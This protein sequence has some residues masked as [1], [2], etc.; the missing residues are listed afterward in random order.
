MMY[1]LWATILKDTRILIRDP[2]G[3]TFMFAMPVL[4]VLIMTSI[5]NNTFELVNKNQT[6]LLLCNRDTGAISAELVQAISKID[7]FKIVPLA[8]DQTEKQITDRMQSKDALLAM[9]I[10]S[11]FSSKI[12]AKAKKLTGKALNSFGLSGD[13]V[14]PGA[15]NLDPLILY[16]HPVIQPSFR[17][18]VQGALGSA[19][20]LVESRQVLR[21]LYLAINEKPLPAA[22][23][24]DML[25]NEATIR[26]I[27]M[28]LNGSSRVPNA[29]EHNVPAWTVFAMFFIVLSLSGS[30]VREKLNGSLIRLKTLPTHY[31]LALLSKQIIY[32]VVTMIQAVMIF[33]IGLWI[34]PYMGL[35]V[36][37]LPA[38]IS[39]LIIVSLLCG[40]CAVSYAICIGVFAQTE[41]QANS[42]GAVSI[43]ILAAIGGL[44]VPGFAMPAS[45]QTVMKISPLHWCLEAYYGLFLE[46]GKLKDIL[47][48]II[49]LLILAVLI[50]FITFWGLKRKRL[51]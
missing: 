20:Q 3:I 45:F 36:L 39:G 7:L 16:Y 47:A 25:S 35:P 5:Q 33:A 42:F 50:Q 11:D 2:I 13:T 19:I 15:D 41:E 21:L 8:K 31:G 10:P 14:L 40:W 4:L 12:M 1:K 30:I 49:P 29:S 17:L 48:N 34:F 38:D 32:L 37:A 6:P 51:I 46:G 24:K 18:S 28:S 43:V 9:V 27:P 44:M 22:L 26:E 23:E